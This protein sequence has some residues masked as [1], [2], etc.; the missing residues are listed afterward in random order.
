MR[1]E[2]TRVGDAQQRRALHGRG[3]PRR[4]ADD[5]L[6][7]HAD[8][9]GYWRS[10]AS[11]PG[12]SSPRSVECLHLHRNRSST[13]ES[14]PQRLP[15][16]RPTGSPWVW[17][18]PSRIDASR[19]CRGKGPRRHPPA[20]GRNGT[21]FRISASSGRVSPFAMLNAQSWMPNSVLI[22]SCMLNSFSIQYIP[23]AFRTCSSV[24]SSHHMLPEL[25][26]A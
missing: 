7:R 10:R 6:V 11:S 15:R 9:P 23:K 19:A 13:P 22:E 16:A 8:V 17:T 5:S 2:R 18:F 12:A 20:F 21:S 24:R 26:L 3:L 25:V 4:A 1:F 14:S